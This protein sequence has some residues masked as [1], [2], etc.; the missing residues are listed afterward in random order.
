[1]YTTNAKRFFSLLLAVLMVISMVPA[2]AYAEETHDHEHSHEQTGDV[3]DHEHEEHADGS[4]TEGGL[5]GPVELQPAE[6]IQVI[7]LRVKIAEYIEKYQLSADMPDSILTDVY[8]ELLGELR[9]E[10][11]TDIDAMLEMAEELSAEEQNKLLEEQNAKLVQRF[12]VAMQRAE[13]DYVNATSEPLVPI[14][15]V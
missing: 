15:G 1:M 11:W 9:N 8:R 3:T 13:A 7:Q 4:E 12:Y 2:P 14:N 5:E 10:A 6:S